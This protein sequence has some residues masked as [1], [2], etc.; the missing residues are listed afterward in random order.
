MDLVEPS[1]MLT[2]CLG[3]VYIYFWRDPRF[4]QLAVSSLVY[5]N[6]SNARRLQNLPVHLLSPALSSQNFSYFVEYS[7][8][9]GLVEVASDLEGC[10][11][12]Q[13]TSQRAIAHG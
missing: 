3:N 13:A 11:I 1:K 4:N 10:E 9:T 8:E 12:V 7:F 2:G 5:P 6:G